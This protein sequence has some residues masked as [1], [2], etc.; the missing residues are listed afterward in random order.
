[1]NKTPRKFFLV[2]GL[3]CLIIYGQTL[4]YSFLNWDDSI[5]ILNNPWLRGTWSDLLRFWQGPYYGLYAPVTYSM[6]SLISRVGEA[7]QPWIFHLI[8]GLLHFLNSVLV[9]L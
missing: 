8:N 4:G 6:W 1:M 7:P 2:I 5:H 3:S 9:T